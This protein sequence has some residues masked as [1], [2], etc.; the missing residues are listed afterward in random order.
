VEFYYK[1][2]DIYATGIILWELF[3]N[4]VMPYAPY[5]VGDP[6]DFTPINMRNICVKIHENN[7]RPKFVVI[8]NESLQ[9]IICSMWEEKIEMRISD[10]KSVL[11]NME[12]ICSLGD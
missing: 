2:T 4:N 7:W 5:F 10:L 8:V 6:I 12:P 3:E 9:K 1:K 11:V